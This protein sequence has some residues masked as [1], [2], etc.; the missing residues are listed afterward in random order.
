MKIKIIETTDAQAWDAYVRT[1]HRGTLYHLSGWKNVI[2]KT[3][4]HKTYY[5]MAVKDDGLV[6]GILPLTHLKH[7]AFGNSLISIPFFDTGG[8]LADDEQTENTILTE[9]A[10][11]GRNL[12]AENIEL[13]HVAYLSCLNCNFPDPFGMK[14]AVQIRSHKV[15]MHLTL[16]ESSEVLMKSFKAKLRSQIKR[17]LKEGLYS[18]IGGAELLDD[19]YEIFL[20][21]M[22][23]LGSPVHSKKLMKNVLEAF[24]DKARIVIVYKENEALACS[25]IIG[26]KDILENPWASAL[27]Q[28]SRLSPNMLLYWAMLEYAC[29]NGYAYFDFG[30]SSPGEGTYKFKAQWGATPTPLNWHIISLNRE[31]ANVETSQASKFDK[32][33]QYWRKL[34][35]SV[36]KIIGPMIRKHIGL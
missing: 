18:K 23:D 12:R 36:T 10:R 27:R 34:P 15:L 21:N 25:F 26:F 19:F 14:E 8:I 11:I 4:G 35:V 17:P 3:Y 2:E 9:A 6:Y 1:H 16:P 13:R 20:V 5:L 7:F 32:A 30:R 31:P 28:Y 29:D 24:P 22:R 33:I